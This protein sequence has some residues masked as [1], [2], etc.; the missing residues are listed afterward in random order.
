MFSF[1]AGGRVIGTGLTQLSSRGG[2]S[3]TSR[4]SWTRRS[5]ELAVN[6]VAF[7]RRLVTLLIRARRDVATHTWPTRTGSVMIVSIPSFSKA[8]DMSRWRDMRFMRASFWNIE[9]NL[10]ASDRTSVLTSN[11]SSGQLS[12]PPRLP[13]RLSWILP[14]ESTSLLIRS[15]AKP[16]WYMLSRASR[17]SSSVSTNWGV[18]AKMFSFLIAAANWSRR[19]TRFVLTRAAHCCQY[20]ASAETCLHERGD[21]VA[22]LV[23]RNVNQQLLLLPRL[24]GLG[25]TKLSL[26]DTLALQLLIELAIRHVNSAANEAAHRRPRGAQAVNLDVCFGSAHSCME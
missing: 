21:G 23:R 7:E 2:S 15:C 12:L 13:R 11:I 26:L 25:P 9:S 1:S 5:V 19:K 22:N 14:S 8:G 6:R 10:F 4:E 17:S 24:L 20:W 3:P 16:H 18:G